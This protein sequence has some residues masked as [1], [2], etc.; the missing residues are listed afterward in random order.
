MIV[1]NII[2]PLNVMFFI[3]GIPG[4]VGGIDGCHIPIKAPPQHSFLKT[5][6]SEKRF[7]Q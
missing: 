7:F 4:I 1:N 5:C 6:F 2:Y 3:T